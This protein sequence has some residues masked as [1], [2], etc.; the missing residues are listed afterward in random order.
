MLTAHGVCGEVKLKCF[1]EDEAFFSSL[2][3]FEAP[4]LNKDF[5][6]LGLRGKK[7]DVFIASFE[8][9]N[10]RDQALQLKGTELFINRDLLP[11]IEDNDEYYIEDLIGISVYLN[12]DDHKPFGVVKAMH[13]FGAGDII[14]IK[15]SETGKAHMYPFTEAVI[16]E[17][18]ID[19][20]SMILQIP[21]T[22]L[23]EQDQQS[24]S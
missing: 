1:M 9:I 23:V 19:R 15:E 13:N 22:E 24:S 3:V 5:R 11:D 4:S 18:D 6:L 20:N 7:G 16:T 14:E 2:E 17:V 12:S 8:E 21:E 10:D